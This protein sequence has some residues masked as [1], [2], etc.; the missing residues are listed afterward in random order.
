MTLAP[1]SRLG[2]Y[3]IVSRIGAGGMGEVFRARDTRLDRSVAI[4]VLPQ[5]FAENAQLKLRFEREAKSISQLSHPHICTLH[6]VGHADGIDYLVMEFLEGETL[7]DRLARGHLPVADVL[8]F[9]AQIAAALDRAHRAGIVHRDLKPGNIMLTKSGAKLLDFGLAR[10]SSRLVSATEDTE[11][12]PLT[13]EG[14]IVG[15]YHYMAPEQ[16]A[17]EEADVRTDIFA[18]GAVLYEMATGKRAFEGKTKTS[19]IAAIVSSDPRPITEFQP[20]TPPA[21]EH[22]VRKCLA[23]DP[24][25]RWQSAGDVAS[26]IDW[27]SGTSMM[28]ATGTATRK[29]SGRHVMIVGFAIITVV[30][31]A[32]IASA[33][34]VTRRLALAEQSVRSEL[35]S[36]ER[37]TPVLFGPVTL[38]PDAT[39]LA[40]LV[41]PPVKPIVAIRDLASG[42][43]K[44][45]VGTERATYPFWSPDS[46]QIGFFADGKLK[47]ISAGGGSVQIV[48]DA[49][50]GRGGSWSH[51][52]VIVFTPDIYSSLYKVSEDG[53]TPV[54]VTHADNGTGHRN[55]VFL[56]DGKTFLFIAQ[57]P[58]LSIGSLYAGSID[59]NLQKRIVDNASNAAFAQGRLF[60]VRDRNLVSQRFDP[61]ARKLS[62][63]PV[64][65]ADHVEYYNPRDVGNFSVTPTKI[66]YVTEVPSMYEIVAYDRNGRT[67]DVKVPRGAYRILDLSP[68]GSTLAV[69]INDFLTT[70]DVWLIQLDRGALSRFTFVNEGYISAVFSP[71]GSRLAIASGSYGRRT[72]IVV[73]SLGSSASET[74]MEARALVLTDW[75]H[76]SRYLIVDVQN[77]LTGFDAESIAMQSRKLT[78]I[79]QSPADELAPA[80][81][82]NGKWLAYASTESGTP[83]VYVSMFPS[84]EGKWQVTQDGGS[85]SRWSRD[86][87]QLFF[88]NN[89]HINAVD[90]HDGVVPEFGS[91]TVLPVIAPS[92]VV[93]RALPGYAVTPDGHF[94][95]VKRASDV[96]PTTIHLVTNW[97]ALLP[98]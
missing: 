13:Q 43:T 76:D 98:R 79:V 19:L 40:M 2:P 12:K 86:G 18:L 23:K 94:I 38:S 72:K 96:Q 44:K 91:T 60:F 39:R 61:G 47:T 15:T 65:V 55:P 54:A 93:I 4:K 95:T 5:E 84:G 97:N 75:S 77:N 69:S 71:D 70:G 90:F 35:L 88:L 34:Y 92:E 50:Q 31:V 1:G 66:V 41:G 57:T 63:S 85:A 81:S 56:P 59:G 6:D 64:P 28:G 68:D 26:E 89:D 51:R 17:G 8:R 58:G 25:D 21:L 37:L 80:L 46:R 16:L 10:S 52:G 36:D 82:P 22:V 49:N 33:I 73:H 87:K 7:A 78:P 20:L 32:A 53:G 9:G 62:G 3:E 42:E 30:A 11:H 83:Q 14:T 27:I 67:T 24:D 45:L 48:C 29:R 74:I